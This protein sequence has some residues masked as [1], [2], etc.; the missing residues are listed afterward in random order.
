MNTQV[1]KIIY[2]YDLQPAHITNQEICTFLKDTYWENNIWDIRDLSFTSLFPPKSAIKTSTGTKRISF[3]LFSPSIRN[4]IKY[5]YAV[6][7]K[8]TRNT[9]SNGYKCE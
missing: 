2:E 3:E 8:K 7:L 9:V 6:K 5:M 1:K 4:E